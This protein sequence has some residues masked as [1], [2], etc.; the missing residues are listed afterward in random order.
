MSSNERAPELTPAQAE[1]LR[2]RA[3]K[4]W[5]DVGGSAET[6]ELFRVLVRVDPG[7]GFA[8]FC[9]G[10]SLRAIGR[11]REAEEALLTSR[12]LAPKSQLFTVDARLGMLLAKSGSPAEAEKWFRLATSSSECPG[13]A[14]VLRAVNL[15]RMESIKLARECL[16]AAKLRGDVDLEE[17]MLNEALIDRYLGNYED[18][19]RGA[20]GAL[21][22]DANYQ[23]ARDLLDQLRGA[24]E[25]RVYATGLMETGVPRE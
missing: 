19:T 18:A 11:F 4:S 13:W 9:W 15:I 6:A 12:D 10:D 3:K 23:P 5:D 17:V 22:I 21:E 7:D 1:E 2:A 20:E 8:W 14:W 25:A 16:R 24:A